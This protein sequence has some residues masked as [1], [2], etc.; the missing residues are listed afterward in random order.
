MPLR[1]MPGD[2][3]RSVDWA[4]SKPGSL[5]GRAVSVWESIVS[6]DGVGGAAAV[7]AVEIGRLEVP[8]STPDVPRETRVPETVMAGP[9]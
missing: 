2:P 1:V 3:G 8:M 4:T 6:S 7:V 5:P 9:P